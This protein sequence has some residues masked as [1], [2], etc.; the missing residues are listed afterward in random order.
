MLLNSL[1]GI[2]K[3]LI[4]GKNSYGDWIIVSNYYD[5][6]LV[7]CKKDAQFDEIVLYRLEDGEGNYF[8]IVS[9]DGLYEYN[10][11]DASDSSAYYIFNGCGKVKYVSS[12]GEVIYAYKIIELDGTTFKHK[13]EF[14]AEDG[15]SFNV[16]LDLSSS[17]QDD[18][19]I[20]KAQ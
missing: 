18:W 4:Y 5:Y 2:E 3:S 20:S 12:S 11:K 1:G 10:V 7:S 16:I 13:L 15:T 14:T 19:N 6:V 8:A 17:S 9:P